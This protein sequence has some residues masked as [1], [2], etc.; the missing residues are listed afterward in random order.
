MRA[1]PKMHWTPE[2]DGRPACNPNGADLRD[3]TPEEQDVTCKLCKA[4]LDRA[5]RAGH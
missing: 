5:K 3:A 4:I 2:G 1:H